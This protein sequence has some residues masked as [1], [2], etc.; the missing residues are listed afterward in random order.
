MNISHAFSLLT[1]LASVPLPTAGAHFRG[2]HAPTSSR[3]TLLSTHRQEIASTTP[4]FT[5]ISEYAPERIGSS[6]TIRWLASEIFSPDQAGTFK[7]PLVYTPQNSD[8][9][10]P[11]SDAKHYGQS[12]SFSDPIIFAPENP[13]ASSKPEPFTPTKDNDLPPPSQ[14]PTGEPGSDDDAGDYLFYLTI[15]PGLYL[16]YYNCCTKEPNNQN[17]HHQ[18]NPAIPNNTLHG[19]NQ[20]LEVGPHMEAEADIQLTNTN[21][22]QG[23]AYTWFHRLPSENT[24]TAG[25]LP[26]HGQYQELSQQ[27]EQ[28]PE[29]QKTILN[30]LHQAFNRYYASIQQDPNQ[31][32]VAPTQFALKVFQLLHLY[33]ASD[34]N[35]IRQ[36]VDSSITVIDTN[37]NNNALSAL[38]KSTAIHAY[39][40]RV[41]L[42]VDIENGTLPTSEAPVKVEHSCPLCFDF[43]IADDSNKQIQYPIHVARFGT[44]EQTIQPQVYNA[45]DLLEY[46]LS[47]GK[48]PITDIEIKTEHISKI[49][50]ASIAAA[51]KLHRSTETDELDETISSSVR[52]FFNQY[53]PDWV[54]GTDPNSTTT[55]A[56]LFSVKQ[57]PAFIHTWAQSIQPTV[58]D[59]PRAKVILDKHAKT[60][61]PFFQSNRIQHHFGGNEQELLHRMD[62]AQREDAQRN[63]LAPLNLT[64]KITY[65]YNN[66]AI[67]LTL[68][69]EQSQHKAFEDMTLSPRQITLLKQV[70][71]HLG[72]LN[73][74]PPSQVGLTKTMDTLLIQCSGIAKSVIAPEDVRQI[75]NPI[76]PLTPPQGDDN[77]A[78]WAALLT[79]HLRDNAIAIVDNIPGYHLKKYTGSA[80]SSASPK[81]LAQEISALKKTIASAQGDSTPPILVSF[82]ESDI[83][84]A[85]V[86]IVGSS[87]TPYAGGFFLF[88]IHYPKNYPNEVPKTHFIAPATGFNR[89]PTLSGDTRNDWNPNL[90]NN[91][92]LCLSVAGGWDS[93]TWNK[94]SS[95][96]QI[97]RSIQGLILNENPIH[98]EPGLSA[99]KDETRIKQFNQDVS[100]TTAQ[101]AILQAMT[102]PDPNFQEAIELYCL[103]NQKSQ[104]AFIEKNANRQTAKKYDQQ[105]L[106]LEKKY[107]E[108]LPPWRANA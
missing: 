56:A 74:P 26:T 47:T 35:K 63:D 72:T 55:H 60:L 64:E 45:Y 10:D 93:S 15:L 4:P 80:Q 22:W 101:H 44:N 50:P 106:R 7:D 94:E 81:V 6:K 34:N 37:Q 82:L 1:L 53:T 31:N 100:S 65:L 21:T 23:P 97:L 51:I 3:N 20:D 39:L 96:Y 89:K 14:P 78:A 91:G 79:Q 5:R 16:L 19:L 86:L 102:Q 28:L 17:N 87:N 36:L 9:Q 43:I 54:F 12:G 62:I 18:Q 85:R 42:I 61:K 67:T 95:I 41:L 69:V 25:T 58:S 52:S 83:S 2:T 57:A 84:C 8:K 24:W 33:T 68:L 30:T 29:N 11:P 66:T 99:L 32:T 90:Y 13:N 103:A 75:Q 77:Q 76:A 104:R 108:I 105:I 46:Y 107:R 38:E 70:L 59:K 98:N 73:T 71:P 27:I 92:K 49:P 88:D 40:D 48:D